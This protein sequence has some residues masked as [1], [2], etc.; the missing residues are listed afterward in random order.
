MR[1]LAQLAALL[2]VLAQATPAQVLAPRIVSARNATYLELL[3]AGGWY[4]VNHERRERQALAWRLG[5]TAWTVTNLVGERQGASAFLAGLFAFYEIDELPIGERGWLIEG[6]VLG[7]GGHHSLSAQ[8]T[9][10]FSG[11]FLTLVPS[12]G[13]RYQRAGARYMLRGTFMKPLPMIGGTARF[14]R[15]CRDVD[16]G[17]SLGYVY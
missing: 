4:S 8:G 9:R 16:V 17:L 13:I 3:G 1:G 2:V 12:A 6:G 11:R 5:A 10:Y 14:P 15:C 7:I